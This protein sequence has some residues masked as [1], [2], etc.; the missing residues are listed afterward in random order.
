[1][2]LR[3]ICLTENDIKVEAP[4]AEN[5][6]N[7]HGTAFA[8][9]IYSVCI[10]TAWGFTHMRLLQDG[11][12]AKVVVARGEI[13][14]LSPIKEKIFCKSAVSDSD[15][16][17]FNQRLLK[18]GK[19]SIPLVVHALEDDIPRATLEARVAVKITG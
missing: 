5:N 3:V 16:K 19:A 7:I 6:L 18:E 2:G 9:S 14:Y 8:G 11:I 13:R 12:T 4:V 15:Y 17:V 10:L 1:M